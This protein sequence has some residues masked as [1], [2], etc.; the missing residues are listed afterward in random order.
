MERWLDQLALAPASK[1]KIKACFSVLF[2]HAIRHQWTTFNPISKVR[3]SS[4]RL[5]E[6]DVLTPKEFQDLLAE[7]S[8][9]DQAMVLLAGSTGLRRSE[10]IALTWADVNEGTLEVHVRRSCVRN[11][12]GDTKT[13]GSARPVPLHPLVLAALLEWKQKSAY[14]KSSDFLFASDRR[15]GERPLSPD[16]IL[17]KNIRPALVRAGIVGK[18]IGWHSFRHSLATNLR[19]IGVDLKVAQEL[20]RHSNSRTTLDVYTRAVSERKREANEKIVELLLPE[21]AKNR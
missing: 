13:E 12:I 20:L 4:K 18:Q 10:L 6:K 19:S 7:L 21:T 5:R 17:K 8:L 3:T 1:A 15:N 9:R 11:R 2:S 16:S 14:R